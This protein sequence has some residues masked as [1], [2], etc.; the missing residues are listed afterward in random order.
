M[1]CNLGWLRRCCLGCQ[2]FPLHN[3]INLRVV[4]QINREYHTQEPAFSDTAVGACHNTAAG[5]P[6]KRLF[7]KITKSRARRNGASQQVQMHLTE[8][9]L[10]TSAYKKYRAARPINVWSFGS[11]NPETMCGRE[12][13]VLNVCF[14]YHSTG[15]PSILT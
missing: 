9:M 15:Q 7:C 5:A 12:D 13:S 2:R 14:F 3:T 10:D 8:V 4:L 11:G 6:Q 1:R